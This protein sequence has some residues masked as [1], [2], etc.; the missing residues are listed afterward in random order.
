VATVEGVVATVG[1]VVAADC[2][3]LSQLTM[4]S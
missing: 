4:V 2:W 3:L 1:C